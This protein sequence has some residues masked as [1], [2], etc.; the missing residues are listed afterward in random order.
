MV[1][2]DLAKAGNTQWVRKVWSGETFS[3]KFTWLNTASVNSL[4]VLHHHDRSYTLCHSFIG[5][6]DAQSPWE[7]GTSIEGWPWSDWPAAMW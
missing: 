4:S 3:V 7:E 1:L 2:G 6:P 5:Q